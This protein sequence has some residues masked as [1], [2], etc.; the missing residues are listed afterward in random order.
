MTVSISVCRST[1]AAEKPPAS[2]CAIPSQTARHD[3]V[4]AV[5]T[6]TVG[7]TLPGAAALTPGQPGTGAL[8]Y[9]SA[10]QHM[11]RYWNQ[12]LS[13]IPTL[14]LPNLTLPDTGGLA[15]PGEAID[16]AY[17][18]ALVYPTIVPVSRSE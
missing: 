17:K 9:D 2:S 6:F 8:P 18:A 16:N 1:L 11:A 3:F 7:G 10:Y 14:S 5:D 4:A 15:N 13:V 12:R